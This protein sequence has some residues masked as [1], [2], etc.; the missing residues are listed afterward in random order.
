M[1][2]DVPL[3]I[4]SFP[5]SLTSPNILDLDNRIRRR[6]SRRIPESRAIATYPL[7]HK[8]FPEVMDALENVRRVQVNG[9]ESLETISRVVKRL[10]AVVGMFSRFAALK[11]PRVVEVFSNGGDSLVGVFVMAEDEYGFTLVAQ[12]MR[13]LTSPVFPG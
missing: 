1:L 6:Y 9:I 7:E 12:G 3:V 4:D 5:T 10:D 2:S 11:S 8:L 13:C